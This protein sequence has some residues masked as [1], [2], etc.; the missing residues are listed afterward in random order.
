MASASCLDAVD[1]TLDETQPTLEDMWDEMELA[2]ACSNPTEDT[3]IQSLEKLTNDPAIHRCDGD[4]NF[5]ILNS[6]STYTC[7][8]TGICYGQFTNNDPIT[9]GVVQSMDENNICR[10]WTANRS[11]SFS[12]PVNASKNAMMISESLDCTPESSSFRVP[13]RRRVSSK[14]NKL[15]R[16]D[17][18]SDDQKRVLH[19]EAE[20]ILDRLMCGKDSTSCVAPTAMLPIPVDVCMRAYIRRCQIGG[21]VPSI[22]EI[23]NI[24]LNNRKDRLANRTK[25]VAHRKA[26]HGSQDYIRVRELAATLAVTLWCGALRTPH[27]RRTRRTVDNFRPYA[28]GV[29]FSMRRGL[30]LHDGTILIPRCAQLADALPDIRVAPRGTAAHATHISAHKGVSTLQRCLKS[31][32]PGE[33]RHMFI[34]AISTSK[35]ISR[36]KHT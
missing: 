30:L 12:N 19:G 23:H 14:D 36:I 21:T 22:N 33:L 5:M 32:T 24:E 10:G 18:L 34:D 28:A 3:E 20:V 35:T 11:T 2:R 4:C 15:H 17:F 8:I 27:M 9:A 29:F 26:V 6:E 13:K 31:I 7:S 1:D 25:D 16:I